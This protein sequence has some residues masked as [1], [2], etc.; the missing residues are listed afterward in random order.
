MYRHDLTIAPRALLLDF[1]GVIFQTSKR[2]EGR[3]E[4]AS[5]IAERLDRLGRTVDHGRLR[6]S[7]D[8]GLSAL[9]HWK[10]AASRRLAP[11]EMTHREVVEDFL[12]SDLS[13]DVRAILVAEAGDVL[14]QMHSTLS[15][16]ALR[17][18]IR[19]TVDECIRRGIALGVVSNA[20]SGRNHR[21]LLAQHGLS[22]AFGVQVYSDEV[23]IR[24]P[25]PEMIRMAACALGVEPAE[26]W[27]VGDTQDRDVV[28]GR[29]AGVGAVILTASHHTDEPPFAVS[30]RADAVFPTPEGLA[31]TLRDASE[32]AEHKDRSEITARSGRALLIDHGGVI[33]T[34][35]PDEILLREFAEHLVH[36]LDASDDPFTVEGVLEL[37]RVA[38]LRHSERKRDLRNGTLPGGNHEVTAQEFWCDMFGSGLS[39]RARGV[40]AAEAVDLMYR[41][42]LAKSRRTLRSGVREL[43][44]HCREEG[45]RVVV[46]SNTI[47]GRAVRDSCVRLGVDELI[48]AYVCSDEQGYRKPDA[49]ILRDALLIAGAAP[50][51]TWFLGDKPQNDAAG[52]LSVG[53]P[54]RI[55]VHGG[56]TTAEAIAESV[57]SGIATAA[58]DSADTLIELIGTQSYPSQPTHTS[59]G[60]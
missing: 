43:L 50:E 15:D 41:F 14:A 40:L 37:I 10:H 23:G 16:H 53:I 13:A 5:L 7:I 3:D 51:N 4:F 38:R 35:A 59:I 48:G 1:G 56:S 31:A 12:A 42:G 46:V 18:G 27:Y 21:A 44:E 30:E 47:S 8:A 33:V 29:R 58:I 32:R 22:Q 26:C 49:S 25:N 9:K 6:A 17:P 11:R 24:K 52:A 60:V 45:I 34:S 36:L 28:A 19:E 20:H 57:A 2:A 39:P 55:M 54:H